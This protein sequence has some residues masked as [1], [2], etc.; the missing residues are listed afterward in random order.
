MDAT[1]DERRLPEGDLDVLQHRLERVDDLN[2][3]GGARS[4]E[5]VGD[6]QILDRELFAADV[7]EQGDVLV[8]REH[9]PLR[10]GAPHLASGGDRQRCPRVDRQLGPFHRAAYPGIIETRLKGCTVVCT[11]R[12]PVIPGIDRPL[13]GIGA[14]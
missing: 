5:R 12:E 6:L 11:T 3:I 9:G 10:A 8:G 13:A 4:D 7:A 1:L 14:G 2:V